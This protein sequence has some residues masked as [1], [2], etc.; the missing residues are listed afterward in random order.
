MRLQRIRTVS[1]I[2]CLGIMM[3]A[4]ALPGIADAQTQD[5]PPWHIAPESPPARTG[6]TVGTTPLDVELAVTPGQ[7]ALGLGYRNGLAPG[8]GML[9][10]GTIASERT[11][12]MKGMRFCLDIVWVQGGQI[13]GAA[14]SVCPDSPGTAD[15]DRA[16]FSSP[17]A[18]TDVLEV[19]AGWLQDHGYG[20]GKA[21]DIPE[22]ARP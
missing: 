20:T 6:I 11:F 21:I 13:V 1:R 9:F 17:G 2:A 18:V 4:L 16:R 15:S 3:M 8:T 22:S 5:A 10:V 19:P 12:W 7:Q 14:E